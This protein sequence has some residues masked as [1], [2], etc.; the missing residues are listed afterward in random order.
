MS[1]TY[2][3]ECP[4]F[5]KPYLQQ[6]AVSLEM[7]SLQTRRSWGFSVDWSRRYIWS[8]WSFF[9]LGTSRFFIGLV[10]FRSEGFRDERTSWERSDRQL[11]IHLFRFSWMKS[12]S[13]FIYNS[14]WRSIFAIAQC[15]PATSI[16]YIKITVAYR[17]LIFVAVLLV[18]IRERQRVVFV[19][20]HG[21]CS[22]LALL[23]LY[24]VQVTF[25]QMLLFTHVTA[26]DGR[27]RGDVI[28]NAVIL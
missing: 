14:S 8:W 5:H 11:K 24:C 4:K 15:K 25:F 16:F 22:W 1:Q 21:A 9:L 28:W 18:W 2:T 26:C 20:L 17:V 12:W 7:N 6:L 10:P 3:F 19:S 27:V 13:F 23:F